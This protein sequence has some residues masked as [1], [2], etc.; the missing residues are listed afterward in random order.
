MSDLSDV[1]W[2]RVRVLESALRR[3]EK[4]KGEFP[5]IRDPATGKVS[6]YGY[7]YGSN[8]ER[9]FMRTIARDALATPLDRVSGSYCVT[10]RMSGGVHAPFCEEFRP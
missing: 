7:E 4:W 8:G 1:L 3:I 2:A 5:T 9:D 10:C 6:S